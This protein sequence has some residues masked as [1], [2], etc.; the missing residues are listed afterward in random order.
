MDILVMLLIALLV[1][2]VIVGL[3]AFARTKQRSGSVLAAPGSEDR[4]G[5]TP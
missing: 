5:G 1:L 2:A 4:N 3:F